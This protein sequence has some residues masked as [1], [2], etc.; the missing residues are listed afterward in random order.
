MFGGV[1][2]YL[3][4]FIGDFVIVVVVVVEVYLGDVYFG[5]D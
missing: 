3:D 1:G 2:G 5:F 4:L